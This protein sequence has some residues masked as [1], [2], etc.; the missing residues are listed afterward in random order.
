MK[1][2]VQNVVMDEK[3]VKKFVMDAKIDPKV[4]MESVHIQNW[5]MEQFCNPVIE[6]RWRILL[7]ENEPWLLIGI[8][9]KDSFLMIQVLGTTSCEF[10]SAHEEIDATA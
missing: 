3:I 6:I 5:W 8:P 10:G 7:T 2:L 1:K 4:V 9:S